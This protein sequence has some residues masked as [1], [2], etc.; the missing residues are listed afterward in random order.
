MCYI[1]KH[2]YIKYVIQY[3]L[4]DAQLFKANIMT[5]YFS[6]YNVHNYI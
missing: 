3:T 6:V 1:Y 4:I 5:L 2:M